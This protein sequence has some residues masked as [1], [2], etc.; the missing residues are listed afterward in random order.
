MVIIVGFMVWLSRSGVYV[1]P[2]CRQNV[3]LK[4]RRDKRGDQTDGGHEDLLCEYRI[5]GAAA[6]AA[7]SHRTGQRL[8]GGRLAGHAPL[9]IWSIARRS[10]ETLKRRASVF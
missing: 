1:V 7:A 2:G 9:V 3:A 8:G 10:Q 6:S 5:A 4:R